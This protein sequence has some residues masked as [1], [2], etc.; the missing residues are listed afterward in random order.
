MQRNCANGFL[1]PEPPKCHDGRQ[2][3]DITN[4]DTGLYS[5]LVVL[6]KAHKMRSDFRG[7]KDTNK[8]LLV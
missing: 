2:S 6:E 3:F 7:K 5:S 4:R 8:D 1:L